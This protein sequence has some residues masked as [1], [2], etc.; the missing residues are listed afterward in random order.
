MTISKVIRRW[1]HE[2]DFDRTHV[3][4]FES[5][6]VPKGIVVLRSVR[7]SGFQG[8]AAE[9]SDIR[10]PAA[11]AADLL[12]LERGFTLGTDRLNDEQENPNNPSVGAELAHDLQSTAGTPGE[13]VRLIR[14]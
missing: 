3:L 9:I 14:R 6:D 7:S 12:H 1:T 10:I 2:T 11:M 5:P 8:D 4:L 13:R